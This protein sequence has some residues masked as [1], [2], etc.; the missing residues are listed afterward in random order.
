MGANCS[1]SSNS[2]RLL[3]S[4]VLVGVFTIIEAIG[5]F[6]AN[7][8]ALLADAGHMSADFV[9]LLLSYLSLRYGN[10]PADSK[11]SYGYKRLEIIVAFINSVA[12]YAIAAVIVYEAIRRF[13]QN[14]LVEW[15]IMLP[16]ALA[17]VAVNVVVFFILNTSNDKNLNMRSAVLH[18][19]GDILGFA[20]AII[21]ALIIKYTGWMLADP[22]LSIVVAMLLLRTAT[23]ITKDSI[24]ILLEGV[25]L[26]IDDE[27]IR[28]LLIGNFGLIDI[29]H[30]HAWSLTESYAILTMHVVSNAELPNDVLLKK[31]KAELR[32][33]GI[34][35]S[36]IE[37]EA[38]EGGC[39]DNDRSG[40]CDDKGNDIKKAH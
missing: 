17:G 23:S 8:L 26:D 12:L 19:L 36:T 30:I 24:H 37:V 32:T 40:N 22:I 34:M 28:N 31:L 10:R 39:S 38:A 29:H 27:R 2:A 25:P 21:A 7:S 13:S 14:E 1:T 6:Y 35:H 4:T 18:I 16:V 9:A 33:I 20:G 3:L 11:R 15:S 5:G